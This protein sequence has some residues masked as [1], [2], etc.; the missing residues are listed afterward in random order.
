MRL[1]KIGNEHNFR[2]AEELLKNMIRDSYEEF[3]NVEV[4]IVDK[5]DHTIMCNV[6]RE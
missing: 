5:H 2:V 6:A 3:H 4:I 1:V